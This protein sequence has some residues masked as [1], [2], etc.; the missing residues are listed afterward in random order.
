MKAC[1]EN[2]KNNL[3]ELIMER[4]KNINSINEVKEVLGGLQELYK[5]KDMRK[6]NNYVNKVFSS[7]DGLVV[8][9]SSMEQWCFNT[10]DIKTLINSHLANENNYWKDINFK[11]EEAKVFANENVAWVVSIGIIKNTIPEDKHIKDTIEKVKEI[12]GGEKKCKTSAL[13]V[14]SK[15]ANTLRQAEYGENYTWPFRFT[16]VLIKENDTWK[17]HQMQFSFDSETWPYR[18]NDKTY[19]KHIFEMPKVNSNEA[20]EE[21]RKT[22]QVFQ[23]G[24]INRDV[25]YVDKYMKEVFLLNEDL[26]VIGTDAGELCF[27][28]DA[29]KGIVESDWKYWGDFNFNVDNALISVS[30][31]VAYFTT[32]AFL[33]RIAPDKKILEWINNSNEY[34]FNSEESPKQKLLTA[35]YDTI[36]YIYHIEKGETIIVPM[37]FSG[38]LVRKNEKWLIQHLQ[39]SDYNE[40]MPEVRIF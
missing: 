17:F 21:V 22:L 33:K 1:N 28:V 20:Y 23:D 26:L 12:L 25:N 14:A 8:F 10:D 19:D 31:D 5:E 39:Y 2:Q 18:L 15:M 13:K 7:K 29:A 4:Y 24:Y 35:L 37:R 27:G 38:V 6:I 3:E 36:E 16:C 30:G 32:K 40:G 9:G 11:F 34:T